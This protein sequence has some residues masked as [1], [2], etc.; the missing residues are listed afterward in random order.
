MFHIAQHPEDI[1][2]V[3]LEIGTAHVEQTCDQL[4]V[5]RQ[6]P[7][8]PRLDLPGAQRGQGQVGVGGKG[9]RGAAFFQ[10]TR[11]GGVDRDALDGGDG[12]RGIPQHRAVGIG[13]GG[14]TGCAHFLAVAGLLHP[15]VEL[16][17]PLPLQ[18]IAQ[19]TCLLPDF[20][21]GQRTEG[22]L[23][24]GLGIG[25]VDQ[26]G[27]KAAKGKPPEVII[28]PAEPRRGQQAMAARAFGELALDQKLSGVRLRYL[29]ASQQNLPLGPALG[30]SPSEE[31]RAELVDGEARGEQPQPDPPAPARHLRHA[32]EIC[33]WPAQSALSCP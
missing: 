14:E 8:H 16:A 17:Q 10:P 15:E 28:D 33:E 21:A 22:D 4:D 12:C 3:E 1:V 25:N 19:R 23:R 29:I 6:R 31:V 27:A 13:G 32:A 24:L 11:R 20:I 9:W 2:G 5:F 7:A 26:A 30:I 18:P